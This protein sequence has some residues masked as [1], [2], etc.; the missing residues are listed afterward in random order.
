MKN[1]VI[2][3]FCFPPCN[4]TPS[5]R[6]YSWA[7]YLNK[8]GYYPI[9]ITRNWDF[10]IKNSSS[11]LY[12][13]SG[14]KTRIEKH[15]NYEVHYVPYKASIRDQLFIHTSQT[16]LY[17]V[18]LLFSVVYSILNPLLIKFLSFK[19]LFKYSDEYFQKH[20]ETK[21][22]IVTA[23]PYELFGIAHT[24]S[25]RHNLK[26]IADYRD[27]WSTSEVY[28]QSKIKQFLLTYYFSYFEKK[29]LSSC[30]YFSSVSDYL[31]DK[32]SN[33]IQKPGECIYN[34]FMPENY[35]DTEGTNLYSD[36]TITYVGSIYPSQP[37]DYFIECVNTFIAHNSANKLRF[38]VLF[39]GIKNEPIIFSH[40]QLATANYSSHYI[41]TNRVPKK[42]AIAMQ[43]K[44]HYLLA[45][46]HLGI[47][48]TPGSKLYEYLA[49]KKPVILFPEK[50]DIV[51][52]TLSKTRQGV[53]CSSKQEL[54]ESLQKSYN[55]F[56]A[57]VP[58]SS[59]F[60]EDEIYLYTREAQTEKLVTLL[61]QI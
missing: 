24:L 18:Y 10:E 30:S 46:S 22:L 5:E 55:N 14:T 2:L 11:D 53:F 42:E 59:S 8:G 47:K 6:A 60:N 20:P 50:D 58:V 56:L 43:K 28:K 44:S 52:N 12:K 25:K 33:F 35:Y 40:L 7:K 17:F 41:F 49:I 1:V 15:E 26:W 48:G 32:I 4:L 13:S 37:I 54:I 39:I 51:F 3:S 34:G 19:P 61:N 9:I 38:K 45:L 36:F 29:W 23:S 27:D 16:K 57:G 21:K 31:V